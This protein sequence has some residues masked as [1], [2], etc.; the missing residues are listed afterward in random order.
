MWNILTIFKSICIKY[1]QSSPTWVSTFSYLDIKCLTRLR[2]WCCDFLYVILYVA[3]NI[4]EELVGHLHDN[5]TL[6][7]SIHIPEWMV[8]SS[9]PSPSKENS[10]VLIN[11]SFLI[12]NSPASSQKPKT[13][14]TVVTSNNKI[15]LIKDSENY[16]I[17]IKVLNTGIL[18]P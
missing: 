7:I 1:D 17:M 5:F 18:I 16:S 10:A 15:I 8:S 11:H 13:K 2:L 9:T 14:W 6:K 4:L 3:V 12:S